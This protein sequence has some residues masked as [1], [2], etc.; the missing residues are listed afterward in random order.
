MKY[1]IIDLNFLVE[2]SQ[3]PLENT[4]LPCDSAPLQENKVPARPFLR[5]L[6]DFRPPL[7]KRRGGEDTMTTLT[8]G[9]FL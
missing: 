9:G 7:Q 5:M 1:L 4:I 8:K 2:N 6:R 3:A